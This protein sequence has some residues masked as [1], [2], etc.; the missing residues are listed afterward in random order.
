LLLEHGADVKA[1][2]KDNQT[3]LHW[4]QGEEVSQ[5]LD[6]GADANALDIK[7]W[8]PLHQASESVLVGPAQVILE[9]D[10]DVNA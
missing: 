1:K 3:T 9:H 7:C 2:D 5:L 8:T 4:A 6:R 10:V